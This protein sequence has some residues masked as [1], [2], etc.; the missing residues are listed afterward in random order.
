VKAAILFSGQGC[1]FCL[2]HCQL[3]NGIVVWEENLNPMNPKEKDK[4]S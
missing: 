4:L 2:V 1:V 3:L